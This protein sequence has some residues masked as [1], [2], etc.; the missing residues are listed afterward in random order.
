VRNAVAAGCPIDHLA[1]LDNFCWCSSEDPER[2]GQLKRACEAIYEL[3]V[4]Y[5]TP[6]ISG[7]DSM[8]ND[9]KGYDAANEPVQIS[10]PPTLLVSGIGVMKN[11][12][13]AVSLDPKA[14]GDIVYVLGETRDELGASEY[15]DMKGHLGNNVPVTDGVAN[16]ALYKK[17]S[18][19]NEMYLIASSM[20]VTL[21]GLGV[22]L[23]KKCIASGLGMNISLK[24]DLRLDKTLFSE[25]TGRVVVTIAPQNQSDFE[26]L[27][28]ASAT[29]IGTMISEPVLKINNILVPVRD[30]EHSYKK[31]LKD[32]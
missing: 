29:K 20:A 1:I 17:L 13:Q 11:I 8:F 23:A 31:T 16:L 27:M 28:G 10:I 22:T 2:L 26:T 24:N 32:F 9:F 14:P 18:T 25:S 4:L 21:G 3:A 12:D 30:M 5:K 15:Y 6:F 19:A 7:K